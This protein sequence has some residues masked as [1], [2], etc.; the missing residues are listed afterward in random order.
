MQIKMII[1]TKAVGLFTGLLLTAS[2]SIAQERP[3]DQ[4]KPALVD[5]MSVIPS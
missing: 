2:L 5:R 4:A 1:V 3:V